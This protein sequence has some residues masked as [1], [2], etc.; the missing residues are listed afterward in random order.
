VLPNAAW[1][2]SDTARADELLSL[3]R[4]RLG[5]P[6]MYQADKTAD[7]IRLK[8]AVKEREAARAVAWARAHARG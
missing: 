6:A 7:W 2:S 8:A 4:A 5:E 1:S 3:T